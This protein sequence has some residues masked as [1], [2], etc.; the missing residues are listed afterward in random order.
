MSTESKERLGPA[1]VIGASR[2]L[3]RASAA[4]LLAQGAPVTISA[5][6][7]DRLERAV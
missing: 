4:E 5:R 2:G 7:G 1:W 3:G 6:P